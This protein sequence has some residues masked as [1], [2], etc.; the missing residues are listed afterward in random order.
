MK[1]EFPLS[2]ENRWLEDKQNCVANPEQD[3][4]VAQNESSNETL[5]K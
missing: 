4:A 1:E 2:Y 3:E 5:E